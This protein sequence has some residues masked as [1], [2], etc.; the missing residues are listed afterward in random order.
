MI[1]PEIVKEIF[2]FS[3]LNHQL[4]KMSTHKNKMRRG[5]SGFAAYI[6]KA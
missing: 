6:P 4:N 1:M 2:K 3:P 5:F